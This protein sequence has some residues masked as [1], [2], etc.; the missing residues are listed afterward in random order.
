MHSQDQLLNQHGHTFPQEIKIKEVRK[1]E[2]EVLEAQ[3]V[4]LRAYLM[5][6]V[7]PTL[8]AGLIEVCKVRPEDPVDFL[9]EY[10]FKQTPGDVQQ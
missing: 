5:K 6:F 7:M 3:S 1:Q 8:T 9:A 2:Q 4:P 10:L